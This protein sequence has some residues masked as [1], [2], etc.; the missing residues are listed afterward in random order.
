M[1]F[2]ED[3]K[4]HNINVFL[5]KKPEPQ[6]V[7]PPNDHPHHISKQEIETILKNFAS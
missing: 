2:L 1:A 4:L 3:A 7:I 5:K 6:P